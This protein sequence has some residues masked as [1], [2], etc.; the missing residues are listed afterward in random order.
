[1]T[2]RTLGSAAMRRCQRA[3][4]ASFSGPVIGPASVAA[5]RMNGASQPGPTARSI[6]SALLRA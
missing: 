1:M 5:T 6:R 4:S 3:S 2:A